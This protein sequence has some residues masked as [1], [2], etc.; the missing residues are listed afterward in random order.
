LFLIEGLP[1]VVLGFVVLRVLPE[2]PEQAR[3]LPD[4]ERNWLIEHISTDNEQKAVATIKATVW[5]SP[6]V[7]LLAFTYTGLVGLNAGLGV[8]LPLI[9]KVFVL[10]NFQTTLVASLPFLAGTI[11]MLGFGWLSD[12]HRWL[13]AL[14]A[15]AVAATGLLGAALVADPVVELALLCFAALGMYGCMPVFWP[16][17]TAL[18]PTATAAAGIAVVN[19]VGNLAGFYNPTIIG[20][21]RDR[22]G[23]YSAGLLWLAATAIMAF[24][25]LILLMRRSR[26]VGGSL[27]RISLLECN[28]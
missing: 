9:M 22:T 13:A 23:S 2:R 11:G 15:A 10:D 14:L 28:E 16:I 3:W 25:I 6:R 20:V 4:A 24:F 1:A 19:S 5:R 7:W 21:L 8:F 27:T 18:L 17:A 26:S 12:R